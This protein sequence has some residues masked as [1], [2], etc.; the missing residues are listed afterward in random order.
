MVFSPISGLAPDLEAW[1]MGWGPR[2]KVLAPV[3]L[4][5]RIAT[6]MQKAAMQY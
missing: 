1:I 5:N 2:A 3:T 6:A 4:R